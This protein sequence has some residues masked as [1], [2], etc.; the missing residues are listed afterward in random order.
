[1]DYEA[2]RFRRL[3]DTTFR[4]YVRTLFAQI[5]FKVA[6]SVPT[7]CG[8]AALMAVGGLYVVQGRLSVGTLL[9]FLAYLDS[10]YW[11]MSALA[12]LATGYASAAA[13]SRRVFEILDAE[14]VIHDAPQ[15][16]PLPVLPA[17]NRGHVRLENVVFGYEPNCA[18][19]K[20]IS[21]EA[22][23]NETVA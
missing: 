9:V 7:A 4:A 2:Q 10:L 14:D 16:R 12:Y 8:S 1:E 3:S 19:L 22:H 20:G 5:H 11:P 15:A 23:P 21:V 17:V 18:V 13:S 6:V